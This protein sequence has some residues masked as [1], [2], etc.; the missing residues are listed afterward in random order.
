VICRRAAAPVGELLARQSKKPK[1][2][3]Q[4]DDEHHTHLKRRFYDNRSPCRP[5]A[6]AGCNNVGREAPCLG[7]LW[8]VA[9]GGEAAES[10]KQWQGC[11]SCKRRR[12]WRACTSGAYN[13]ER[14]ISA[15]IFIGGIL[16][17]SMK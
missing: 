6:I 11:C 1:A 12:K 3:L 15:Y 14:A 2:S 9:A 7:C 17:I 16:L 5:I 13:F 8:L 10:W 4:E